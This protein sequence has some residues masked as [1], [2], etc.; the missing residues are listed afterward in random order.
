M[1]RRG[2]F[3]FALLLLTGCSTT[4]TVSIDMRSDGSGQVQVETQLDEE[5]VRALEVG[6]QR[7]DDF[8][9]I[10][11]LTEAG[12]KIS[13]WD[14][15]SDGTA[16]L[17]LMREFAN[18]SELG[19]VVD[20][21]NGSSGPFRDFRAARN[22]QVLRSK[23]SVRGELDLENIDTGIDADEELLTNLQTEGVDID[24]LNTDLARF[25]GSGFTLRVSVDI[26]GAGT[27]EWDVKPGSAETFSRSSTVLE[28]GRILR[29]ILV[30]ILLGV[31][32]SIWFASRKVKKRHI[33]RDLAGETAKR[34]PAKGAV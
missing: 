22:D 28:F 8:V 26:P 3:L 32:F 24:Q 10:D 25:L 13:P 15:R 7:L 34:H 17:V 4:T 16:V 19:D 1:F 23:Y 6:D 12:W 2:I 20:Q 11:D 30:L 27:K 21:L 5:A 9:R 18:P 14:R 31:G 29:A 33:D